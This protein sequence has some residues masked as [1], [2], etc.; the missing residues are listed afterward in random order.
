MSDTND[1]TSKADEKVVNLKTTVD[2]Q[3]NSVISRVLLKNTGG[4]ITLFAFDQ[5]EGLS[6]HK[7]PFDAF[8]NVIE[9]EAEIEI[10]G[11]KYTLKSG[12]SIVLPANIPHAVDAI[13]RFKMLLV[14]IKNVKSDEH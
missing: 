7:A 10:A 11:Q 13:S 6:E 1:K 5:G 3:N 8:V 12:D 4:T 14:M 9:G 2:F